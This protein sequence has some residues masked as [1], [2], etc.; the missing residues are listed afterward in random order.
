MLTMIARRRPGPTWR[1]G[2]KCWESR[3]EGAAYIWI[4]SP[5]RVGA[6]WACAA[7]LLGWIGWGLGR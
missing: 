4:R 6:L 2:A 1:R 7:A 5:W 3:W